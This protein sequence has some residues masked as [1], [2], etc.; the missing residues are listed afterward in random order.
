MRHRIFVPIQQNPTALLEL[1]AVPAGEERYRLVGEP[2]NGERTQFCRG[3][4]VECTIRLLPDGSHGLVAT[5]SASA[6][7][8]F[9]KR[10]A[11][12]AVLG[13]MVGLVLGSALALW[14]NPT[15]IS[16]AIGALLGALAFSYCS[17]RW[18]DSAWLIL[19]R[20]MGRGL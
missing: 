9:R 14:V 6:D 1:D 2:P 12:Y 20:V 4:I 8:E 5:H 16:V 10:R 11:V 3:E 13:A 19:G 17:V 15:L 7:P 18:G